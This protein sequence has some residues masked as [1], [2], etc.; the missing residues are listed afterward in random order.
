ML[1]AALP[2]VVRAAGRSEARA[3]AI[4]CALFLSDQKSVRDSQVQQISSQLKADQQ[5][6]LMDVQGFV[7]E[8]TPEQ[9]IPALE[10]AMSGLHRLPSSALDELISLCRRLIDADGKISPLEWSLLQMLRRHFKLRNPSAEAP[11]AELGSADKKAA[12]HLINALYLLDTPVDSAKQ[13]EV[14]A[15][16]IAALQLSDTYSLPVTKG[17]V[18]E[19]SLEKDLD[20]LAQSPACYRKSFLEVARQIV[21]ANNAVTAEEGVL[22]RAF[23]FALDCPVEVLGS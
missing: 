8:L 12:E 23:A 17:P 21:S 3:Y 20:T 16:I 15:A 14:R 1:L 10:L 2:A 18:I 22:L 19:P 13:E 11:H 5:Q 4:C 6:A 7:L 9:R